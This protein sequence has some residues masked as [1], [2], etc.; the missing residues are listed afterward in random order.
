ML[1]WWLRY[2]MS[3]WW[4]SVTRW[5]FKLLEGRYPTDE[6]VAANTNLRRWSDNNITLASSSSVPPMLIWDL[7]MALWWK[8]T[9]DPIMHR[10][11]NLSTY[12][13]GNGYMYSEFCSLMQLGDEVLCQKILSRL[14]PRNIASVGSVCKRFY[15]LTKNDE[16]W[17]M[18]CQNAWGTETTCVLDNVP[19]TRRL[20]WGRIM[21][22][23][24]TLEAVLEETDSWRCCG[25]IPLQLQCLCCWELSHS[26]RQW[27][28]QY[29]TNERYIC[30]G[31]ECQEPRVR[32]I[33]SLA[34]P[35]PQSWH[36]SRTL[37]GTKLVVSGGC[38]D[39][40]VLL[41]DT[42]LLD[43]TMEKPVWRVISAS[44]T[45]LLRD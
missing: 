44:C 40:G 6:Q 15:L 24:M 9:W 1:Q 19:G 30:V 2:K 38:A 11:V 39:S 27:W 8:G 43:V 10:W 28:C 5:S 12:S 25:A 45:R 22:E 33:S 23:L 13:T 17:R 4:H 31:S 35:M 7:S 26:F 14:W 3:S 37:D 20:G 42:Y 36:S 18:V 32:E 21:R 16:L 29:A 41:S 34:P